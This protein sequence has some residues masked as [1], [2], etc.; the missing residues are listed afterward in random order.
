MLTVTSGG[1]SCAF[2]A[3]SCVLFVFQC[4]RLMTVAA[5]SSET[6]PR[7]VVCDKPYWHWLL[8]YFVQISFNVKICNIHSKLS[9]L[10]FYFVFSCFYFVFLFL[11][12]YVFNLVFL[13]FYFVF[14][15]FYFCFHFSVFIFYFLFLFLCFVFL[16]RIFVF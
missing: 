12:F 5:E 1:F 13:R 3:I 16:F 8:G 2:C 14:L 10:C 6:C 11:C 7:V 15:C 4:D 9:F